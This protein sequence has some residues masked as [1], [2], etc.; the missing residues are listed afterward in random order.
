MSDE[1]ATFRDQ[2]DYV[3]RY[4]RVIDHFDAVKVALTATPALHTVDIFG[5]PVFT[6]SY[7]RAVLDK[8]LVPQE[9]PYRIVTELS[10]EGG[11]LRRRRDGLHLRPRPPAP[12]PPRPL[13]DELDFDV[14]A[15]NRQVKTPGF[16]RAVCAQIADEIDPHLADKTLVFC[17]DDAHATEVTELLKKALDARWG[18]LDNDA[19]MKITGSVDRPGEAIRR[20]ATSASRAVA[21]TVDLLTTGI[22]VPRISNLVF[23]RRVRSRIL[24]EQMLGRA[25]RLCPEIG[26]ESF[27]VYDAVGQTELVG[28]LTDM[29]PT[30]VTPAFTFRDLAHELATVTDE[31]AREVVLDAAR[32]EAPAQA[33]GR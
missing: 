11:L 26:K 24:Y 27:R 19:V 15:F 21:V 7:T 9:A 29:K 5:P 23:L 1:E 16:N 17:V 30:A 18:A 12:T 3:S 22:D 14:A 31:R 13:E 32:H 6:Y 28:D 10:R 25:T 2:R 33:R 8:V 20:L 4:R